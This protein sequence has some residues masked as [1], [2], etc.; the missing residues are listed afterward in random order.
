MKP[1]LV[2]IRSNRAS[3]A[4][5]PVA[6]DN[7][8]RGMDIAFTLAAFLGIGW[9]IDRWLG[10]FPLFTIALVLIAAAGTFVR[11]RYTYEATMQRLEAERAAL[12]S[13]QHPGRTGPA[14]DR[15]EDVA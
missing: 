8:G 4:P 15:L 14:G 1:L 7:L 11:L 5:R 3:D 6:D 2:K 12:R 9:L 10:V 13:G